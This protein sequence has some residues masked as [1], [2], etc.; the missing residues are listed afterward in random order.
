MGDRNHLIPITVSLLF[1]CFS[2][3]GST[4]RRQQAEQDLVSVLQQGDRAIHELEQRLQQTKARASRHQQQQGDGAR[5]ALLESRL[6]ELE[7]KLQ[8]GP[9]TCP[10]LEEGASTGAMTL[11]RSTGRRCYCLHTAA[12]AVEARGRPSCREGQGYRVAAQ[13]PAARARVGR[14]EEPGEQGAG[15]TLLLPAA[16]RNCI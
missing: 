10:R 8:V 2:S 3:T 6:H 5:E 7:G 9:E 12:A 16:A 4:C 1:L 15:G 11:L 14:P 13:G